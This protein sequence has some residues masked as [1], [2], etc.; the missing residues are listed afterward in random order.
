M[1][2]WLELG[3]ACKRIRKERGWSA[4]LLAA[5]AGCHRTTVYRL[6]RCEPVSMASLQLVFVALGIE[7]RVDARMSVL[8][9]VAPN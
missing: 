5:K 3:G 4:D 6:E 1:I 2:D 8:S 9:D 7:L